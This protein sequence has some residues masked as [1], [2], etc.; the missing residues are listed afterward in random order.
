MKQEIQ[1]YLANI[2]KMCRSQADSQTRLNNSLVGCKVVPYR[3]PQPLLDGINDYLQRLISYH[4]ASVDDI[5][6]KTLYMTQCM[7]RIGMLVKEWE[8]G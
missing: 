2:I 5:P 3:D 4:M 7:E 8:E 1:N 6:N